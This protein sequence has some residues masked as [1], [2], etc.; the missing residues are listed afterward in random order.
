LRHAFEKTIRD[1]D[2]IGE[3]KK[4]QLEP[5][6]LSAEEVAK[7]QRDIISQPERVVRAYKEALEIK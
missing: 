1:P 4:Q 3:A 7:I 5:A 2:L 6:P